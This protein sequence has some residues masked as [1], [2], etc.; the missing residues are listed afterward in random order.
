MLPATVLPRAIF[1]ASNSRPFINRDT[2]SAYPKPLFCT[3]KWEIVLSFAIFTVLP[4]SS[5]IVSPDKNLP[6]RVLTNRIFP[7]L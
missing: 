6:D 5:L 1:D 3:T 4:S 7:V 2:P